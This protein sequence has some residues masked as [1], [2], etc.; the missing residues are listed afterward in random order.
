MNQGS[1]Y[2]T[3][4]RLALVAVWETLIAAPIIAANG[5]SE[6]ANDGQSVREKSESG[7][8]CVAVPESPYLAIQECF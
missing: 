5:S 7:L 1:G 3:I 8:P 4:P 2:R 6:G